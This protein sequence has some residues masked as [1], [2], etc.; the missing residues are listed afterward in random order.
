V[1]DAWLLAHRTAVFDEA[2]VVVRIVGA[3]R[4]E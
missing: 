1:I 4:V 3:V 2:F